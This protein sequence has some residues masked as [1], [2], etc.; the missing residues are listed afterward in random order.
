MHTLYQ[1]Q[2][3]A[4]AAANRRVAGA[5]PYRRTE[6]RNRAAQVAFCL[7]WLTIVALGVSVAIGCVGQTA[8][9]VRPMPAAQASSQR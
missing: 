1:P 3:I 8:I 4:N 2:R 9:A 6:R 5:V 7:E